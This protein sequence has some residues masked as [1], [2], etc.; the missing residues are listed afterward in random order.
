MKEGGKE[1]CRNFVMVLYPESEA[2]RAALERIEAS[3]Y[4]YA[5]ILHDRCVKASGEAKKP[6]WHV[7]MTLGKRSNPRYV[8][9]I[10]KELGIE[11]NYVQKCKLLKGALRYL[12]H[13]DDVDKVQYGAEEVKGTLMA[14]FEKAIEPDRNEGDVVREV[15]EWV[16]SKDRTISTAE[17]ML[18]CAEKKV[19]PEVRRMQIAYM[20]LIDEHN[21]AYKG[22]HEEGRII[23]VMRGGRNEC[24][25]AHKIM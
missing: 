6:H 17:F 5:Y 25:D 4:A 12:I 23:R 10:A 7:V 22:A 24:A 15:V 21:E 18:M 20:R 13:L 19:L 14:E 11:E 8:G 9:A 1:K 2:H 3:G 16:S